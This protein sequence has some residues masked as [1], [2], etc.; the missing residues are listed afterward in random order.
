MLRPMASSTTNPMAN[1]VPKKSY[2]CTIMKHIRW[3]LKDEP[4]SPLLSSTVVRILDVI[5]EA[6]HVNSSTND[7]HARIDKDGIPIG[8][9]HI[10]NDNTTTITSTSSTNSTI[11]NKNYCLIHCALG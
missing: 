11:R 1:Q 6:I 7:Y 8:S 9:N 10:I 2:Y 5:D 3:R 4:T